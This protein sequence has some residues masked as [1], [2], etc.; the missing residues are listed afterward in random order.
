VAPSVPLRLLSTCCS[1]LGSVYNCSARIVD[2]INQ[3]LLRRIA[4]TVESIND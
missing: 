2:M 3:L 1:K 4:S